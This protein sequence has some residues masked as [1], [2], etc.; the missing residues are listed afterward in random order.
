MPSFTSQYSFFNF[1]CGALLDMFVFTLY[2][3]GSLYQRV[4]VGG[5]FWKSVSKGAWADP[6]GSCVEGH[7]RFNFLKP[8]IF[9]GKTYNYTS[10]L[11]VSHLIR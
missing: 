3:T 5:S 11:T 6:V 7:R 9:A 2:C 8:I 4:F 1:L 10:Y